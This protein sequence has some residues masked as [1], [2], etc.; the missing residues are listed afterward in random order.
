ML[1]RRPHYMKVNMHGERFLDESIPLTEEFGWM[2]S[3]SLDNQP[4]RCWVLIDE[5]RLGDI[6]AA[7][8]PCRRYDT[9]SM[10][11]SPLEDGLLPSR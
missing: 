2:M 4:A 3:V 1:M 11:D 9:S 10:L 8:T 5:K 6:E 7:E